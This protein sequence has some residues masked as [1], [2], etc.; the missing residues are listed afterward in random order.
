MPRDNQPKEHGKGQPRSSTRKTSPK[1]V[2]QDRDISRT[3]RGEGHGR[4]SRGRRR[5]GSPQS[6]K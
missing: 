2:V 6:N 5:R 4:G 3:S 1:A